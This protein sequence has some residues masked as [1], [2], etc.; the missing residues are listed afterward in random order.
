MNYEIRDNLDRQTDSWR[1]NS[2]NLIRLLAAFSIMY[3]HARV[4]MGVSVPEILNR[5]IDVF[6]GV[7]IFFILSGYLLWNSVGRSKSF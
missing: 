1:N 6:H 5:V 2:L 7:P 4:H 3:G